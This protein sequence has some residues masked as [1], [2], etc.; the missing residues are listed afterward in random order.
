MLDFYSSFQ[1]SI[2]FLDS[3][4]RF[5]ILIFILLDFYAYLCTARAIARQQ[6][7]ICADATPPFD[8]VLNAIE[9]ARQL[10]SIY[11]YIGITIA[12]IILLLL[13]SYVTFATRLLLC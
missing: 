8:V 4:S 12:I 9:L 7:S 10:G 5:L 2:L 3:H 6:V 13:M 1:L 11:I